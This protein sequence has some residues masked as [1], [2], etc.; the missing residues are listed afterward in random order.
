[1]NL[2]V[3]GLC[4]LANLTGFSSGAGFESAE[5]SLQYVL[6]RKSVV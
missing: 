3:L 1:M 2:I 4:T 5:E 6:D